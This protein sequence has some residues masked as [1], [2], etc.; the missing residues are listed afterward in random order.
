[1]ENFNKTF[2][3]MNKIATLPGVTGGAVSYVFP[4][5][6]EYSKNFLRDPNIATNVIDASRLVSRQVLT[7]R[8]SDL[9]DLM[10]EFPTTG[11]G[12]NSSKFLS[13][14]RGKV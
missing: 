14:A 2:E 9:V 13:T 5:F 7:E 11:P 4:D 8:A 12:F 6:L 10:F 1:M 3:P